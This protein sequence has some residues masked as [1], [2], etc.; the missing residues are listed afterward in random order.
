MLISLCIFIFIFSIKGQIQISRSSDNLS[1]LVWNHHPYHRPPPH[2]LLLGVGWKFLVWL[3]C[4]NKEAYY[5]LT[6]LLSFIHFSGDRRHTPSVKWCIV[7]SVFVF[8]YQGFLSRTLMTHRTAGEGR[9]HLLFH[10]TTS[11]Y[12]RTF[13]H[14]FATL[15]VRLLSL[16]FNRTTSIYQTATRWDLPP[17]RITI[18]L[19]DDLML[20]FLY[21]LDDLIPG[22]CYSNLTQQ[23]GEL[24]LASTTTLVLQANQLIKCISHPGVCHLPSVLVIL[25][26]G[27]KKIVFFH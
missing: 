16:I 9:D 21:F 15:H 17:Y 11:I 6:I 22:F 3:F 20:I 18:W 23:T 13:R 14:L 24:E 8:F 4:K 26:W 12:L 7:C 25:C 2:T 27:N 10:F 5:F 19:I 1:T